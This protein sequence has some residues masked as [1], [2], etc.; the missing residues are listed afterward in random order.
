MLTHRNSVT[1]L[2][3]AIGDPFLNV[4]VYCAILS[5]GIRA[6]THRHAV[7]SPRRAP[8]RVMAHFASAIPAIDR[9]SGIRLEFDTWGMG[10]GFGETTP[11]LRSG[12][13]GKADAQPA[14]HA[15]VRQ[16]KQR[17]A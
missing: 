6:G 3:K 16:P 12:I 10:W 11:V 2:K 14:D 4:N 5:P 13:K 17:P 8:D 9:I 15:G 1:S 7:E